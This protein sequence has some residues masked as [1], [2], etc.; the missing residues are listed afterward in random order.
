MQNKKSFLLHLDSLEVLE[1]MNGE[2][3]KI[4]MQAL[5]QWQKFKTLPELDFAMKMAVMPFINQF[6][7]DDEKW[8]DSS[9]SGRIGNLKKYQPEIYERFL[10]QEITLEQAEKE[11]KFKKPSP[12]IA[13]DKKPSPPTIPD[14]N[15]SGG[16]RVASLSVNVSDSVSVKEPNIII[17]PS[18]NIKT[19][20]PPAE[21][22]VL[23]QGFKGKNI[24]G[25]VDALISSIGDKGIDKA[26]SEA[27]GWDIYHLASIYLAGMETRG[28][29]KSLSSA[30]AGWCKSYTKNKTL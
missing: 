29:P 27:K 19:P 20:L 30:F 14:Q 26:K 1:E 23:K 8:K 11:A 13:P 28:M 15:L 25:S 21:E 5:L 9:E 12:P 10:K 18:S 17:F 24:I 7:R 4:L 3:V 16:D 22:G 6:K 2:Q